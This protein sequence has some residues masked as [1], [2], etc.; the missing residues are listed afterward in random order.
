M[1]KM[2]RTYLLVLI[3]F[4]SVS[5][6]AQKDK[7]A[8]EILDKTT[9]ALQQAGGIRATFGGT[10]NGTL[11]LKGNQFY[12]N[13]GGIQSWFDGKTQWSYLESSEEVNVSNPTPEELQTINPYALLSIYKNGYNYKYAGTKSRNG[14]QGFEVILT[15]ENKQDITSITLFVSQTYQPLYIKVEQNNKSAN[16]IIVTSYQTNQPLDNATFKFDKKK[17]PNAEVIDLR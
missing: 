9:N 5:L 10:G 2:K 11:L 15:P 16:E 14:K 13:S 7:Q 3:L 6:S 4:L 8:R 12:L 17:F 1:I